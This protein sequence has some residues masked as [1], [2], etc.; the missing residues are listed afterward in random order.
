MFHDITTGNNSVPGVAGFKAA[1]GYDQGSGLGSVDANMLVNR[2]SDGSNVPSLTLTAPSTALT[3][4][5]GQT[6]NITITADASAGLKSA[7]ALTVSG[8]PSGVTATLTPA[9]IAAPG[10]G[11]TVLKLTA[12][13]TAA[14]GNYSLMV[15]GVGGTQTAHLTLPLTVAI[16]TFTLSA[17]VTSATVAPGATAQMTVAATPQNGFSWAVALSA[18]GFP[19]GVTAAF[20][21]TTISGTGG[22][23]VLTITV[24]KT[25][26]AGSYPV[27]IS[28]AG[29]GMTKTTA[30]TLVVGVAPSCSLAVN[31]TSVNLVAG[32]AT[33]VQ[34][35]CS[36]P[37]GTFS[38][39]LALSATGAPSGVTAQFA[40]PT[41][42][43]GS[44]GALSLF[45]AATT[46]AGKYSLSVT[47]VGSGFTQSVTL[48][49]TIA[50][51]SKFT[52]SAAQNNLAIA[53]G[54]TGQTS[55]TSTHVGSFNSAIGIT[56][57][58]LP[59]GVTASFSNTT[60][61][62]PGD[63]TVVAAFRVAATARPGVYTV[64]VVGS[65]G[66][67]TESALI[68]V[69]IVTVKPDFSFAVNV[70]SLTAQRGVVSKPFV[71][72]VGDFT[73]G[74]NSTITLT[75]AGVPPGMSYKNTGASTGN[76]LINTLFTVTASPATPVG[77]YP[78]TITA[79]GG[80]VT[81]SAVISVT[82]IKAG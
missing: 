68:T 66:G 45:S 23:S 47:A 3:L 7:V 67:V 31:P 43:P 8:A 34:I 70:T 37:Q 6:T 2:W 52:L 15:T 18:V 38:A 59:A 42:M 25:V 16:P 39:P 10:S 27:T 50:A 78:V 64:A 76:N 22:N 69:T 24:A 72:S 40:M 4:P 14:P 49:L 63:G 81:H 28:A 73:G 12:A 74:F 62:A 55:V 9:T 30:V 57:V 77:T 46:V 60:I 5:V 1:A 11:T 13:T 29:G 79:T 41:L 19:T 32:Q 56:V 17:S 58:G 80:G 51:Q 65:G 54:G 21:P 53:P 26:K 71:V 33:G 44:I 61:A 36:A 75:F 35:A 82:V 20:S 48:P